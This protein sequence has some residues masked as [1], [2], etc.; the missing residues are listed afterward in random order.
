MSRLLSESLPVDTMQD[1]LESY[2]NGEFDTLCLRTEDHLHKIH[3][4]DIEWIKAE[5]SYC[6]FNL[7]TNDR[8]MISKPLKEYVEILPEDIFIRPH[9][10]FL[11]NINSIDSYLFKS[12]ELQLH[13]GE[14]IPVSRRNKQVM[15][16]HV[17]S[18]DS[19]RLLKTS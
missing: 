1:L 3:L 14:S 15:L 16:E 18:I 12:L 9:K 8:I 13:S 5:G 7:K 17:M 11:I 10:S 2:D 4:S 19:I 6:T